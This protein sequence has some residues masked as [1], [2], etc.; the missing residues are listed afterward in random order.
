M[1]VVGF[2]ED[3]LG[4]ALALSKTPFDLLRG[5]S[6][7][8]KV[9]KNAKDAYA[10]EALEVAM[11]TAIEQL[12]RSVGDE[13]TAKLAASILGDEEKMLARILREIPKLTKAVVR[14]HVNGQSSYDVTTTGAADAVREA[15]RGGQGS[16]AQA[17]RRDQ[18]HRAPSPQGP[19][20]RPG[21]GSDQGCCGI[22]G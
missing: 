11:Y 19:G 2:W 4:Q 3:V 21:R 12:A 20:C 18:T 10:T 5:S 22:R 13:Q 17:D 9:L 16:G 6:G 15:E 14:A 7:E 8:E 1:A